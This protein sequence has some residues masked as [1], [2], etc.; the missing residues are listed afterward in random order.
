ML[1]VLTVF[2]AVVVTYVNVFNQV[3]TLYFDSDDTMTWKD[4]YRHFVP[5]MELKLA[6]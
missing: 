4:F 3:A 5:P 6:L 2:L 1:D